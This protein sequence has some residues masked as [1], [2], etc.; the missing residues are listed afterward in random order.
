MQI[1]KTHF[2]TKRKLKENF[3]FIFKKKNRTVQEFKLASQLVAVIKWWNPLFFKKKFSF[4]I[5]KKK[6]IFFIVKILLQTVGDFC[7]I[8]CF[9]FILKK[10]NILNKKILLLLLLI[11]LSFKCTR[12]ISFAYISMCFWNLCDFCFYIFKKMTMQKICFIFSL[13][14]F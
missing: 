13:F 14:F 1:M 9:V 11:S 3:I 8:F 7:N 10:F 4:P 5:E 2:L 12:T 6:R